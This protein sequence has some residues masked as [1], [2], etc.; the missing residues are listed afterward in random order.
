M[1]NKDIALIDKANN[2]SCF[3]W[4][5]IETLIE[6][7][8]SEEAKKRLHSIMVHKYHMEEQKCEML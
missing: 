5:S 1:S 3:D 7:A 6:Q 8:S 2:T 4:A